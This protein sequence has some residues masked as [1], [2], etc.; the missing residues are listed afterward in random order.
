VHVVNGAKVIGTPLDTCVS[1]PLVLLANDGL[2][3]SKSNVVINDKISYNLKGAKY[4][5]TPLVP[6]FFSRS[7]TSSTLTIYIQENNNIYGA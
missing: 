3:H 6:S 1:P 2:L 5:H 7:R 4:E